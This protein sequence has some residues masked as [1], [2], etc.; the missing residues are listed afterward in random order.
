[1]T[2]H[3]CRRDKQALID[4]SKAAIQ[5]AVDTTNLKIDEQRFSSEELNEFLPRFD[6]FQTINRR[7]RSPD[8][9]EKSTNDY[10]EHLFGQNSVEKSI[11]QIVSFIK[12]DTLT[13]VAPDTSEHLKMARIIY[14]Q[15]KPTMRFNAWIENIIT[16]V[17]ATPAHLIKRRSV[18]PLSATD[19]KNIQCV[20]SVKCMQRRSLQDKTYL[21]RY[22]TRQAHKMGSHIV[23]AFHN[24][25]ISK[26]L[27][28]L[29][30]WAKTKKTH[31]PE[32]K[33][34]EAVNHET[35]AAILDFGGPV[36]AVYPMYA[37]LNISGRLHRQERALPLIPVLGALFGGTAAA[38]VGTSIVSGGAPLSWFGKPLGKL[39]GWANEND[40]LALAKQLEA[41]AISIDSL[42]LSDIEVRKTV[43]ELIDSYKKFNDRV[44]ASFEVAAAVMLEED[45]KS[46][47][48]F[49]I[50]ML[51]LHVQKIAL[52]GV[53]ASTGTATALALSQTELNSIAERAMAEKGI[54]LSTDLSSVKMSMMKVEDELKLIFEIPIMREETLYHFH[55]VD[56]IPLFENGTTFLP[57]IDAEFLGISK[58]GSSY[59]TLSSDE[60]ARCTTDPSLCT[61]SSPINPMTSKAHCTITTYITGNMTCALIES[62]KPPQKYIHTKGNH[63][64]FSVP[65][66]TTVFIK[67]DDMLNKVLSHETTFEMRDMGQVTFRPGCN[68]NFPDGTKFRTPNV[69]ET[70]QLDDLHLFRVL[71]VYTIPKNARIKRFYD[72]QHYHEVE[73][74]DTEFRMPS[75][76]ELG[77]EVFHPKKAL[78]FAVKFILF[79]LI[80]G[81]GAIIILCN[82]RSIRVCLGN[83]KMCVCFHPKELETIRD[84]L[85]KEQLKSILK[86]GLSRAKS[87]SSMFI[88]DFNSRRRNLRRSRSEVTFDQEERTH[89]FDTH[90][91]EHDR[92]PLARN[93]YSFMYPNLNRSTPRQADAPEPSPRVYVSSP[94]RETE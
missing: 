78:S 18:T 64:I 1:M 54:K 82:W 23:Y 52:I 59:V 10:V 63:T 48:R 14:T 44:A 88:D 24:N 90:E 72:M 70:E 26:K 28:K 15:L 60:F 71:Q 84:P 6:D 61:V 7:K 65:E 40:I 31:R 47:I 67:C 76:A 25:H 12:D 41:H 2:S 51:E 81:I 75:M 20:K 11:K 57:E 68:I 3:N 37:A 69:Y 93:S 55:R 16:K 34:R 5:N 30:K 77:K 50:A 91:D 8:D 36:A 43:N 62:D 89:R 66:P 22:L 87:T 79:M 38:N 13:T 92:P 73:P 53:A 42:Q 9:A 74:L 45:L 85:Q 27:L 17:S 58:S 32:L 39:F 46:F 35:A 29:T 4:A 56:A 86:N 94:R 19:L 83:T 49:L 33:K 80:I 21:N